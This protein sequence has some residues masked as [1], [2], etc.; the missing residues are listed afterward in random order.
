MFKKLKK[1]LG[2][3]REP[4]GP[5][6]AVRKRGTLREDYESTMA[7]ITFAEA[8][9]HEQAIQAIDRIS[10]PRKI[11]VAT[12]EETFASQLIDYSLQLAKRLGHEIVALSIFAEKEEN[13]AAGGRAGQAPRRFRLHAADSAARFREEALQRGIAFQHMIRTGA[14][15]QVLEHLPG[16]IR[17]IDLIVTGP[18]LIPESSP[19]DAGVPVFRVVPSGS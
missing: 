8:G 6:V 12:S 2:R 13:K 16:E 15:R 1:R 18:D 7:A 4:A 14:A 9:A 19:L 3:A 17:R 10:E 11:V 5:P